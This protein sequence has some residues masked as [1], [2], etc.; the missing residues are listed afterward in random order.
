MTMILHVNGRLTGSAQLFRSNRTT[1]SLNGHAHPHLGL[2]DLSTDII[3]L[4][5]SHLPDFETLRS[6]ILISKRFSS[7]FDKHPKSIVRRV[8]QNVSGPPLNDLLTLVRFE[9]HEFQWDGGS[10]DEDDDEDDALLDAFVSYF[11]EPPEWQDAAEDGHDVKADEVNE[12]LEYA[13]RAHL[14]EQWFSFRHKAR[15]AN[16]SSLTPLESHKFLRAAYRLMLFQKCFT[17]LEVVT[18]G[19]FDGLPDLE[20]QP[21]AKR[22][23]LA[24]RTEFLST[25]EGE[26]LHE[27]QI[28]AYFILEM[29]AKVQFSSSVVVNEGPLLMDLQNFIDG[30]HQ[31]FVSTFFF[32]VPEAL[33]ERYLMGPLEEA[34]KKQGSKLLDPS[35]D[36]FWMNLLES[37]EGQFDTCN[38][39][40]V[41]Q[42]RELWNQTN[43]SVFFV[44]TPQNQA[45]TLY[46]WIPGS[47]SSHHS[48]GAKIQSTLVSLRATPDSLFAE[49]HDAYSETSDDW[50][51]DDWVCE[52]CLVELVKVSIPKWWI[53]K[54]SERGE[55]VPS[56]DCWYGWNCRTMTH[57]GSHAS[58]LNHFCKPT[59]GDGA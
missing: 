56:E 11:E 37:A 54:K 4:I 6:A 39:C 52:K 38:R 46:Q 43:W 35:Q 20:N 25:F 2:S 57:N 34:L 19:A 23:L 48:D 5:F 45:L 50:K 51:K 26:E 30:V 17:Y 41:T 58:K 55:P 14:L 53:N 8:A 40:L 15:V 27:I 31:G 44:H 18:S 42:G 33:R 13:E 47:L 59:R 1:M 12:I 49:F 32:N 9:K 16:R 28:V 21:K 3:D 22:R 10:G 24:A 36:H 29:Q 7:V